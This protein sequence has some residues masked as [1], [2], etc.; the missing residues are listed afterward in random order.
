MLYIKLQI[1]FFFINVLSSLESMINIRPIIIK[2]SPFKQQKFILI[3]K[4]FQEN[5]L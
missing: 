3:T 1:Q 4:L 2:F 5:F